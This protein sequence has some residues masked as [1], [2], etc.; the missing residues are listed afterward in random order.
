V[1]TTTQPVKA[2]GRALLLVLSGT[3]LIDSLEV[4]LLG[5]AT[6]SISREFGGMAILAQWALVAFP[7]G[8]ATALVPGRWLMWRLGRRRVYLA[9]LFVFGAAAVA[10]GAAPGIWVLAGAE[11]VKGACAGVTAPAG[12]ALIGTMFTDGARQRRAGLVYALFG[13]G[14]ATAGM[15]LSGVLSQ[16]SWRW[17][18]LAPAPAALVLLLAGLRYL[19]GTPVDRPRPVPLPVPAPL[20]RSA[21]GAATLNGSSVA[22]IVT[23]NLQLQLDHGWQAWR[24]A[25]VCT[26]AFVTLALSVVFAGR[27]V[28]RFGTARPVVLGALLATAGCGLYAWQPEPASVLPATALVGLAYLCSFAALNVGGTAGIA[29]ADRPAAGLVVQ[30]LVQLGA[31]LTVPIAVALHKSGYREALV[32]I[33]AVAAAGLVTALA[34]LAATRSPRKEAA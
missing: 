32:F 10:A 9:A 3:M 23:A 19:P 12:V 2:S 24:A 15:L 16:W 7:L 8:F 5:V 26:P 13:T 27:L 20:V 34:G 29:P 25:L 14:G 30:L 17:A 6:P 33:T 31:A 22:L 21:L 11:F 18:V 1:V 4:A 28:P